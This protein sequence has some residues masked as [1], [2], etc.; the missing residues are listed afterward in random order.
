M[1]VSPWRAEYSLPIIPGHSL[2]ALL[3]KAKASCEVP[4]LIQK[5]DLTARR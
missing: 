3:Q 5:L 4:V 2:G 1:G